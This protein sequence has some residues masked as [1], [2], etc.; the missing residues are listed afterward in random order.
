MGSIGLAYA[1]TRVFRLQV[2]IGQTMG[3][4]TKTS[5]YVTWE[6]IAVT[7]VQLQTMMVTTLHPQAKAAEIVM[8]T[9]QIPTQA[10]QI[11]TT[12]ASTLVGLAS[13]TP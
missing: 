4:V 6:P 3:F 12:T 11:S 9:I 5:A 2:P 1:W 10:P 7:V 8:T 13:G